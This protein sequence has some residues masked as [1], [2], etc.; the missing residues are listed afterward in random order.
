MKKYLVLFLV[1]VTVSAFAQQTK[2]VSWSLA[3]QNV[4]TG[5]MVPFSAPVRSW[6]G[7]QFR[8]I[9]NPGAGCYC[10]VIYESPSGDDIAVLYSGAM[11]PGEQWFSP[12]ME[13]TAPRGSES[14]FV[15]VSREEQKVLAQR[16]SALSSATTA[17]QRRA[18]MNEIFRVRSE[19]SKFKE[20]PEKPV[21][22]GGASRGAP[23]KAQGVEYSGL[24]IYVKTISI[25][26]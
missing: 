9:V 2:S 19:A 5:D 17:T 15:V 10:Y 12:V 7:E 14:L 21:L 6:N 18:L 4:K 20:E 8:L 13:L 16:I 11:K 3:L 25:E 1:F 24:D 22:M 23:D 26:H